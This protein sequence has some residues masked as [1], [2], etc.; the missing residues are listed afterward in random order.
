M[1][2]DGLDGAILSAMATRL[3]S[4]RSRTMKNASSNRR[5]AFTG[6]GPKSH[7]SVLQIPN[8]GSAIAILILVS[9]SSDMHLP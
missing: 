3:F 2:E 5:L 7:S 6:R 8:V 4:P 9:T 1:A